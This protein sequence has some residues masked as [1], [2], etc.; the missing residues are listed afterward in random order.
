MR[1]LLYY[2]GDFARSG[3]TPARARNLVHGLNQVDVS[4]TAVGRGTASLGRDV[5]TY[6]L[7]AWTSA[8]V[9]GRALHGIIRRERPDAVFSITQSGVAGVTAACAVTR[10]PFFVDIHGLPLEESPVSGYLAPLK[11]IRFAATQA[12]ALR[13]ACGATVVVRGLVDRLRRWQPNLEVVHGAADPCLFSPTVKP[14]SSLVEM[15]PSEPGTV[16]GYVGNFR[17]YQGVAQLMDCATA[18]AAPGRSTFVFVG[19]GPLQQ[20]IERRLRTVPNPGHI[21]ILPQQP[22]EDVASSLAACDVLVVPRPDVPA[23]RNGFPSKLP[24]YMA[25]GKV[26][27]TTDVGDANLFIRDGETGVL[28]PPGDL[29]ALTE[30]LLRSIDDTGR[31]AMGE[32]ARAETLDHHTWAHRAQQVQGFI[33]RSLR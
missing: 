28:V 24:E 13:L 9:D 8:R 18:L 17:S 10:T 25:M 26:V 30:A 32:R 4:V 19:S 23:T 1:I 7:Q 5:G 29:E 15:L 33:E 22:Y 6:E 12:M 27:V 14:D 31:A 11:R 20:D 3:G 21:L 2:A 16:V